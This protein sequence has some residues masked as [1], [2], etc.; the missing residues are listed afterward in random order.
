MRFALASMSERF[1]NVFFYMPQSYIGSLPVNTLMLA[2]SV[3]TRLNKKL[4]LNLKVFQINENS[5]W[6]PEVRRI[7]PD[8]IISQGYYPR[9]AGSIPVLWET[10]LVDPEN[11]GPVSAKRIANYERRKRQIEKYGKQ[12]AGIALRGEYSVNLARR[13]FPEYSDKIYN[14][15]FYLPD[16]EPLDED[17]VRQKHFTRDRL[18][19]LFVGGQAI[20]KG[21]PVLIEAVRK[22]EKIYHDAVHLHVVSKFQDGAVKIPCADWI[23][24]YG[25]MTYRETQ[26]FF[27]MAHVYVMPSKVESFGLAYIEGLANGCVVFARDYEPQREFVDYGRAGVLN[28]PE[29]SDDIAAKIIGLIDNR[30]KCIELA[31]K[32]LCDFRSKWHWS[33]VG[34]MWVEAM[35]KC[36]KYR[37][38]NI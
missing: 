2:N 11:S 21:L 32:G 3:K 5:L 6:L 12:A 22:V 30:T 26:K 31:L 19:M 34:R 20:L 16:L 23:T 9:N 37:R 24:H 14:L 36:I 13:I 1:K 10:Y 35:S 8:I 28:N 25:E 27:Q 4:K 29:S 7:D 38:E 15:P 33:V 17:S 18:E